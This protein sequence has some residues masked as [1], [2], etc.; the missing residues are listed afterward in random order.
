QNIAEA[1]QEQENLSIDR[2]TIQL[3]EPLRQLGEF[4]VP[5]RIAQG[6]EPKIKVKIVSAQ[7]LG[8]GEEVQSA[9]VA[10]VPTTADTSASTAEAE[11]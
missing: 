6:V 5:I 7:T 10:S 11:A 2:R 4:E 1:L 3:R 9:N 8:E